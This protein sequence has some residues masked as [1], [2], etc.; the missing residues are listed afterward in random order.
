AWHAANQSLITRL[1]AGQV[2]MATVRERRWP[3]TLSALGLDDPALA[4]AL[5]ARLVET[6]IGGVRLFEDVGTLPEDLRERFHVGIITNG[7]DDDALDS[8]RTKAARTGL[9]ARVDSFLAS[10][11]AGARKPGARIFHLALERAGIAPDEALYVGDNIINDIVGAK[12]AGM[13]SVLIWRAPEPR[14][15]LEGDERPA[16]VIETLRELPAFLA[17]L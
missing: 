2:T 16:Q 3:D 10:D 8:Q 5:D 1:D 14:P 13:M 15:T 7:A 12:R 6:F 4:T 9:L 11:A 17:T